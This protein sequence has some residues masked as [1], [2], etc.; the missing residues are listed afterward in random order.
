MKK[1][2]PLLLAGILGLAAATGMSEW[3]LPE[4][5]TD[6]SQSS[7]S[8][9]AKPEPSGAAAR[10]LESLKVKGHAPM[11]GYDREGG[12]FGPDYND[13][14]DVALGRNGCDTRNDLLAL[15][16]EEV[17]IKPGTNDCVVASGVLDDPYG[18][19]SIPYENGGGSDIHLE[20][21][22]SVPGTS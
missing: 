13:D 21:V 15:R 14:V 1:T 20:H 17:K 4:S 22:V 6:S 19:T 18:G 7:T 12:S 16:L 2:V 9:S 3:E 5:P 11:T 8:S 10:A